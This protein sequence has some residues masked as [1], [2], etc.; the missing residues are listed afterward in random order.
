M[1]EAGLGIAV[2]PLGAVEPYLESAQLRMQE[3]DED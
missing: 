3:I 2:L 1:V